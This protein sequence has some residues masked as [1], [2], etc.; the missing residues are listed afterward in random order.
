MS[1]LC[2]RLQ[3]QAERVFAEMPKERDEVINIPPGTSKSLICSVMF[4]I[5]VWLNMPSAKTL[6]ASY[7]E[8]LSLDLSRKSRDLANSDNFRI[9]FP[10]IEIKEDQDAKYY[11]MNTNGGARYAT[12][13]KGTV[14]GMHFHFII[15]DDPIDPNEA[16]SEA[17][18]AAKNHWIRQTLSSRKIDKR[19]TVTFLIMQRLHENDPT[20]EF[21]KKEK[22][23]HTKIPISLEFEVRPKILEKFYKNGLLDPKR[24]PESVVAEARRDLGEYGFASQYG[25]DPVPAG[26]GQFQ[27]DKLRIGTPP[28]R[29][30]AIGRYWDLAGTLAKQANNINKMYARTSQGNS[31]TGGP[32][33]TAGVKIGI[34]ED[35]RV[36]ILHVARFRLDV[37][38]RNR[39]IRRISEDDGHD[40]PIGIEQEGGSEGSHQGVVQHLVGHRI[41]VFKPK[42]D[43]GIRAEPLADQVNNG[44]VW[45]A[46]GDW[47]DAFIHEMKFF[48][49]GAFLDQIDAASGCLEMIATKKRRRRVIRKRSEY[50]IA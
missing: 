3:R 26:G 6:G 41:K 2:A 25:Q 24:M 18:L 48:P 9:C 49:Y 39:E 32:K 50:I 17:E 27:T 10:E 19:I 16:I 5:W 22:V 35:G 7:S 14:T 12:G 44:N 40:I 43:K 11:F 15:I 31:A 28:F 30:K 47:H 34:A 38:T 20:A 42:G 8:K 23:F 29:M 21:L 1:Y 45:L 4:P 33:F 46:P 37:G 13:S 36:F